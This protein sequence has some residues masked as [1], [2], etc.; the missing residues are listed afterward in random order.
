MRQP[1]DCLVKLARRTPMPGDETFGR[2]ERPQRMRG[3]FA[4]SPCFQV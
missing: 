4:A 3:D 2:Q 1:L